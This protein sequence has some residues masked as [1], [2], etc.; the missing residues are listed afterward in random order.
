MLLPR[1][2]VKFPIIEALEYVIPDIFEGFYMD[3]CDMLTMGYDEGQ[4]I[5]ALNCI[6]LREDVYDQA[7]EDM[8]RARFTA[9]HELGHFI[10]HRDI[11][12]ARTRYD[13]EKIYTD[14]EWQADVFA[15]SL[16]MPREH[17]SSFRDISDAASQCGMSMGAAKVMWSKYRS[18]RQSFDPHQGKLF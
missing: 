15:G 9:C 6:I 3:V 1:D 7:C 13:Y 5:G 8:P 16:L 10:M 11:V 2:C 12:L 17:L 18:E 14:S 4:T